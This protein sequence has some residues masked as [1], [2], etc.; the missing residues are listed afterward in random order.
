M[1]VDHESGRVWSY[2]LKDKSILTGEGW[3]QRRIVRDL[4][5][6]GHKEIRLRLKSDQ[7]ASVV[8]LQAEVQRLRTG[9]TIPINSPVGESESNGRVENGIKRIQDKTRTLKSHV[10]GETG[11]KVDDLEDFMT[12]MVRWAGELV[13]KYCTGK[14]GKTPHERPKGQPTSKPL[15]QFGESVMYLPLDAPSTNE[16]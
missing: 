13:T 4:E 10:E 15:A 1:M 12:W 2:A 14:G 16:N 3:I 9:R 6:A 5:N 7:E 11:L 8:A